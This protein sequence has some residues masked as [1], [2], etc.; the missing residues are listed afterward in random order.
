MYGKKVQDDC[1]ENIVTPARLGIYRLRLQASRSLRSIHP[2]P[3]NQDN[4][5]NLV[6]SEK[7]NDADQITAP[8]HIDGIEEGLEEVLYLS[9]VP[10]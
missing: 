9:C 3:E 4:R 1:K 5:L 6:V 10:I 8:V 7:I 2:C